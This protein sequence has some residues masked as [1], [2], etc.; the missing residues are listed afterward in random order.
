VGSV[1]KTLEHSLFSKLYDAKLQKDGSSL[2][3]EV[4][5]EVS[6]ANSDKSCSNKDKENEKKPF[7][8]VTE[9]AIT[10]FGHIARRPKYQLVANILWLIDFTLRKSEERRSSLFLGDRANTRSTME[11]VE[12]EYDDIL[13][14]LKDS[15]DKNFG[16]G[17]VHHA[18][19]VQYLNRGFETKFEKFMRD[20]TEKEEARLKYLQEQKTFKDRKMRATQTIQELIEAD[21]T[22]R[23]AK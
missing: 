11:K 19:D 1:I 13:D 15:I 20:K 4:N 8:V 7:S 14:V 22:N 12:E 17:E 5:A 3:E 9:V 21:I 16:N 6:D 18:L 23:V 2:I 10:D